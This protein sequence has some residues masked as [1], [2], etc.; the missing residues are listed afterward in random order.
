M[1]ASALSRRYK[2]A[3]GRAGLR[4]LRFHD[5]RHTFGTRAITK[6]DTA[7]YAVLGVA[8]DPV[9]SAVLYTLHLEKPDG[10]TGTAGIA[11]SPAARSIARRSRA[12]SP[13][14]S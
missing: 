9:E 8:I 14:S 4:Q 10:D 12:E 6:A 2:A 5:L 11:A 7:S 13:A 3:L 1:V